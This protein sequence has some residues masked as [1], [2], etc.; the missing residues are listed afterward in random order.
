ML[1]GAQ[2]FRREETQ[3]AYYNSAFLFKPNHSG[4]E[5]YDKINMVPFSERV[6]YREKLGFLNKIQ[7]GQ[8]D[9]TRGNSFT[10]FHL[11]QGNFGVLICFES[12]FPALVRKFVNR[13]ADFLVNI[14][15]DAWF[16]KTSGP[17]QHAQ[18]SV[19]RAIENRIT[20]ARCA[21]TGISMFVDPYG[22]TSQITPIGSRKI[23]MQNVTLQ[24][25]KTFYTK[26]GDW[27]AYLC[28]IVALG[29]LSSLFLP[30]KIS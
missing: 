25:G 22:R 20:I 30:R 26:H 24:K 18:A 7:L 5:I 27:L 21:N 2:H 14:T 6:P 9:F 10:V 16:G 8:S 17:F 1:I 3:Y 15:N 4:F 12:V 29:I 13:G 11:P 28:L 23:I 19:F